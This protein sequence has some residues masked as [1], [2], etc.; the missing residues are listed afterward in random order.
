[1]EE[2]VP[3]LAFLK[4][5]PQNIKPETVCTGKLFQ[6]EDSK[7]EFIVVA[8]WKCVL[9]SDEQDDRSGIAK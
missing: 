1:M 8:S 6:L 5:H 4:V 3:V 2:T 9:L 7:L